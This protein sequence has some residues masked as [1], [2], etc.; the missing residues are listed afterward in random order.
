MVEVK[1]RPAVCGV[2][3]FGLSLP[4]RGAHYIHLGNLYY[5][6]ALLCSSHRPSKVTGGT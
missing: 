1:M 5:R 2:E 4:A 6:T 3:L